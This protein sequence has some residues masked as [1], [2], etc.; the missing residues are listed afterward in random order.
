MDFLRRQSFWVVMGGLLV[1][2][3]AVYLLGV[4]RVA[5][6]D[7]RLSRDLA[8]TDKQLKDL[9]GS[10]DVPSE[11]WVEAAEQYQKDLQ[12][13]YQKALELIRSRAIDPYKTLPNIQPTDCLARQDKE[14]KQYLLPTGAVFKTRYPEAVTALQVKL[15]GAHIVA[16]PQAVF[17]PQLTGEI[18]DDERVIMLQSRYWL[19]SDVV[20]ALVDSQVP[21]D[22]L[23]R[24]TEEFTEEAGR[25]GGGGPEGMGEGAAAAVA[26]P[27]GL[28]GPT[29]GMGEGGMSERFAGSDVGV[30]TAMQELFYQGSDTHPQ[31]RLRLVV[32]MDF[33][34]LPILIR[35]LTDM[36]RLTLVRTVSVYRASPYG[37]AAVKPLVR[38]DIRA[39]CLDRL[40]KFLPTEVARP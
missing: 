10:A 18:P 34:E 4:Q 19:V 25:F 13:E 26:P 11:R 29:G 39:L 30:T 15:Q 8:D 22:E 1:V 12:G 37:E 9:S 36:P 33:R 38:V 7:A 35:A 21:V 2:A 24:L 27:E 6:E 16:G 32:Q 20:D 28:F 40:S 3:L 31:R 14:G 23:L 17:L 5:S